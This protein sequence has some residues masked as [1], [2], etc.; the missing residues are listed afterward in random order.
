MSLHFFLNLLPSV[1]YNYVVDTKIPL[2]IYTVHWNEE[3]LNRRF[4][5]ARVAEFG[6]ARGCKFQVHLPIWW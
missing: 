5:K 1:I 4:W 6:V 2:R 3:A